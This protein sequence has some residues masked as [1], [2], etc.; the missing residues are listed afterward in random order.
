MPVNRM[1]SDYIMF[2]LLIYTEFKLI[3]EQMSQIMP[4]K[5]NNWAHAGQKRE[6]NSFG[7]PRKK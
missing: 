3:L 1:Q 5:K 2:I 4:R 6:Y 7:V